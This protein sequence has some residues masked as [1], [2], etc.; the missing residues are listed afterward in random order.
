MGLRLGAISQGG[1]NPYWNNY[2]A[3]LVSIN[4]Y[5]VRPQLCSKWLQNIIAI[6][7]QSCNKAKNLLNNIAVWGKS[8]AEHDKRLDHAATTHPIQRASEF[9]QMFA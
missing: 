6:I 2:Q 1:T 5:A 4:A 9:Q 8:K 7:I 3:M